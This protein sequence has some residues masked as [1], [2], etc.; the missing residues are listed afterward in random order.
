[1]WHS[2]RLRAGVLWGKSLNLGVDHPK[3]AVTAI[4]PHRIKYLEML[5][6]HRLRHKAVQKWTGAEILD[7]YRS[8]K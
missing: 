8:R 7:W 4:D 6:D 2:L 3:P 1:M 5:H